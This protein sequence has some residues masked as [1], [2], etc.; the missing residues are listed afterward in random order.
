M[1]QCLTL[2]R[3]C[4]SCM[5]MA[6]LVH[7][8]TKAPIYINKEIYKNIDSGAEKMADWHKLL[9]PPPEDQG[10]IPSNHLVAQYHM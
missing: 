1:D 3:I 4:A 8:Q 5:P 6:L 9:V 2:S 10:R 7:I